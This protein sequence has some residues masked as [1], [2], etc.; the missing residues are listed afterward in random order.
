MAIKITEECIACGACLPECPNEAIYESL[1][2]L[3][4]AGHKVAEGEGGQ[5]AEA[6][7]GDGTYVIAVDRCTECA[8]HFDEPQCASVCPVDDCCVP[9]P[10]T[11]EN[12]AALLEKA[13]NLNPGKDID[14]SK[15]WDGV[16]N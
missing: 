7:E 6:E 12:T 13:R 9:D 16:R 2:D 3:T 8:G 11:P 15:V 1:E 10:T 4:E 5:G 14:D